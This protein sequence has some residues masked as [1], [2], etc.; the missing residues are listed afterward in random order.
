MVAVVQAYRLMIVAV[1]CTETPFQL[2]K[3]LLFGMNRDW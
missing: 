2:A 3:E 1:T